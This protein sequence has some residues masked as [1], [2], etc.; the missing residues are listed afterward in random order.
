[1]ALATLEFQDNTHDSIMSPPYWWGVFGDLWEWTFFKHQ[2]CEKGLQG[3][4]IDIKRHRSS[5]IVITQ[6]AAFYDYLQHIIF[7]RPLSAGLFRFR[8]IELN[9]A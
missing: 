4:S 8:R 7:C 9:G 2:Q 6:F 3:F 5:K 1:M